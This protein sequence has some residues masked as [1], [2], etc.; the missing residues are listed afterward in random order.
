MA[1]FFNQLML[2]QGAARSRGCSQN[3]YGDYCCYYNYRLEQ[4]SFKDCGAALAP[5]IPH[6]PVHSNC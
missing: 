3:G 1:I 6:T 2:A 5:C 4:G